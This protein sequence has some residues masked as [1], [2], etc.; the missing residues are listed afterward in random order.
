MIRRLVVR[1]EQRRYTDVERIVASIEGLRHWRWVERYHNW[2]VARFGG[3]APWSGPWWFRPVPRFV[4][5]VDDWKNVLST[6]L[7][8]KEGLA[9]FPYP[10]K[11]LEL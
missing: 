3:D 6:P 5:W 10:E 7:W 11:D 2:D 8:L 4:C 1:W 9:R